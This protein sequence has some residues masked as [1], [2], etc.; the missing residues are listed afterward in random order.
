MHRGNEEA[1]RR[2]KEVVF[3]PAICYKVVK[4]I[5]SYRGNIFLSVSEELFLLSFL[6]LPALSLLP[7]FPN[8]LSYF[9]LSSNIRVFVQEQGQ[10][11]S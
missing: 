8:L 2:N 10:V 11:K 6:L 3:L 9:K 4:V 5:F 7:L 1:K